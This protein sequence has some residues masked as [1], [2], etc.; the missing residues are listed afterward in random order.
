MSIKTLYK[1]L[2]NFFRCKGVY[3]VDE[4]YRQIR[5]VDGTSI[6]MKNVKEVDN[7]GSVLRITTEEEYYL[8]NEAHVLYH[9]MPAKTKV[10]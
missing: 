6:H 4:A 1:G 2:R 9:V 3:K 10:F 7:T 5:F 8:I